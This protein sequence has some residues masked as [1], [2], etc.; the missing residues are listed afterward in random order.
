MLPHPLEVLRIEHREM[1]R[2]L[3]LL[4]RQVDLIEQRREADTE[5]LMEIADYFRTY[6]DLYHH[7]K[8][9]LILRHME[10]RDPT[11]AA[12]FGRLDDEH[13]MGGQALVRVSRA[14]VAMLLE[15]EA[16]RVAFLHCAKDFIEG[17]RRHIA[18]EDSRFF[19]AA[20]ATLEP[21]DWL[22][23][24]RKIARLTFPGFEHAMRAGHSRLTHGSSTKR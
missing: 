17:E 13:E 19:E 9:D 24:D 8:E 6:P 4:E 23:I 18:W 14:L 15:P 21:A 20:E 5:L 22:E 12:P 3:D 7:P 2:Y 11:A 16:G 1:R 10:A